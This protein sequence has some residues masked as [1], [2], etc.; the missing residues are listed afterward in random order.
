LYFLPKFSVLLDDSVCFDVHCP[1]KVVYQYLPT[2]ESSQ[3][4]KIF[5]LN[6]NL[7]SA[8]SSGSPRVATW[9]SGGIEMKL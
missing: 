3:W 9:V 1:K 6:L 7:D 8:H 5:L 2:S 4:L